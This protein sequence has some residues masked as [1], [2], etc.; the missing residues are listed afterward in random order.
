MLFTNLILFTLYC[1][2]L[3]ASAI[4][5]VKSLKKISK[6]LKIPEFTAAFI[7][8][9]VA[10]SLP[11]L[12]VGISSALAK[13]P[14][15]S[16]GNILGAGLL[17]LTLIIGIFTIVSKKLPVKTIQLKKEASILSS[18]IILL[19][20]LFLIDQQL[21]RIDGIILLT[22]FTLN[23]HRLYKNSKLTTSKIKKQAKKNKYSENTS[24][25]FILFVIGL[26]LL[27]FS[28]R[29]AVK[30]AALIAGDLNLPKII[31]GLFLI[32]IAT[33]L[34]ELIFGLSAIKMKHK[35]MAIGDQIGTVFANLTL[36]L[37]IVAII[38]PIK[39]D[40]SSFIISSIF[41]LFG[42]L[43]FIH[44]IKTKNRLEIKE[45]ILLIIFYIL[46]AFTEIILKHTLF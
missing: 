44:F 24:K 19:I 30:Y 21:S 40:L 42:T 13:N 29:Y 45:G 27:F 20:I 22:L 14:E 37:G 11:E 15:L 28:S 35:E 26:I 8:M 36:I 23:T 33:T 32:S 3:V 25:I 4:T 43:L 39:A 38:Q 34:P 46:F 5:L 12:F 31:I 18:T 10:T 7:I 16:L 6:F 9:A 41:F 17:N 1:I 2:I